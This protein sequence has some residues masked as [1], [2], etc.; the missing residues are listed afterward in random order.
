MARYL[1][2]AFLPALL[3][4]SGC[5]GHQADK[6]NTDMK[7]N[8][9]PELWDTSQILK[10]LKRG[11]PLTEQEKQALASRGSIQFNLDVKDTEEVQMLLQ[12]YSIDKRINMEKWLQRAEP[13][14][15]Y[16]RAVL[17]SYNL[18]PDLIALPFIESGY[19]TMTCSRKSLTRTGENVPTP[20]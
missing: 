18:P 11:R 16:V 9:E 15:P 17:A 5:A 12:Y 6:S 2:L 1:L 8:L 4:L 20:T 10:D 7:A 13:H 3:L 19:N 14:L